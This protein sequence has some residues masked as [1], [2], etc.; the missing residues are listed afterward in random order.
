VPR[1]WEP[2]CGAAASAEQAQELVRVLLAEDEPVNRTVIVRLLERHG[3]SVTPVNDGARVLELLA[4]E[5][6][7]VV[8]MDVQ[9]PRMDGLEAAALIRSRP[10][11]AG[12][13]VPIV[14]LTA[15]ARVGDRE[16][17]LAAG[18]NAYVSKPVSSDELFATIS[19]LVPRPSGPTKTLMEETMATAIDR[20]EIIERLSGDRELIAEVVDL[21]VADRATLVGDLRRAVAE[22]NLNATREAPIA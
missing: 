6:F 18:M 15:H 13:D 4:R 17:C 9:M 2:S 5:R 12:G 7:D 8:V 20:E 11:A 19:K 14:A 16:R 3:Y 22:R 21:F 1:R 10:A